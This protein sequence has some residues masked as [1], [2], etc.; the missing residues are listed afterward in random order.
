MGSARYL[1]SPSVWGMAVEVRV[2]K[3]VQASLFTDFGASP[4]M[5][6]EEVWLVPDP[7]GGTWRVH[8]RG[9]VVGEISADA[10]AQ[11]PDIDRVHNAARVPHTIAGIML[12]ERGLFDATVFLPPT[13]LAVPRNNAPATARVLPPGDMYVVDATTGEFS[14]PELEAASPGQWLVGLTEVSGTVVA[15]LD[16]RVLGSLS[17]DD[18]A[19]V[20]AVLRADTP[21]FARAF[22]VDAMV[23]LDLAAEAS[24]AEPLPALPPLPPLPS[25]AAAH[26]PESPA[27][28]EFPDGTWAITVERDDAVGE[29]GILTPSPGARQ[30][31]TSS[32]RAPSVDF[33]PTRTWHISAG[34]YLSEVEKV[35]LRRE[36]DRARGSEDGGRHRLAR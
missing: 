11:F 9:G 20:A 22:A 19:E 16:G 36:A 1:L 3:L 13:D 28:V 23:G 35:R 12:N 2:D 4:T 30:V 24:G 7:V 17:A 14:A 15:T 34:N 25:D 26:D 29:E 6:F 5:H 27:V 18:S 8:Y 33:T 32:G 31:I 10:R 21:T